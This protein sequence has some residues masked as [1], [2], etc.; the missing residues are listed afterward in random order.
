MSCMKGCGLVVLGVVVV[1]V[2]VVGGHAA[3]FEGREVRWWDARA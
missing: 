3:G 1:V 2:V